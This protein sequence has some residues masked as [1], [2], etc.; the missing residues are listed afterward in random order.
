MDWYYMLA[1]QYNFH[2]NICHRAWEMGL[3]MIGCELYSQRRKMR[4]KC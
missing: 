2:Y 4:S 1:C 3:Y